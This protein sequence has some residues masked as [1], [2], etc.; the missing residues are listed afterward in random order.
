MKSVNFA[1]RATSVGIAMASSLLGFL[2]FTPS[3]FGLVIRPALD[4]PSSVV[5]PHA[6][7]A[8][9]RVVV[10]GGMAGWEITVIAIGAALLTALV[11][12]LADRTRTA[13]RNMRPSAA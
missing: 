9:T 4:G 10:T 5:V 8:V 1:R 13:H 7:P 3:A 2:L 12:V 6:S 11:A